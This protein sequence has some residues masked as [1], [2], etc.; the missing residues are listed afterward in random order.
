MA[1]EWTPEAYLKVMR[2][3]GQMLLSALNSR[4]DVESADLRYNAGEAIRYASKI[5]E[6]AKLLMGVLNEADRSRPTE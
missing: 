2:V 4:A 5:I 1:T 6:N 3:D